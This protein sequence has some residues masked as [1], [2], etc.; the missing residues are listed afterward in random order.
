M[1]A[2]VLYYLGREKV[3]YFGPELGIYE[4]VPEPP[5]PLWGQILGY[6]E[7]SSFSLSL[8]I[9]L[10]CHFSFAEEPYSKK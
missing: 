8:V 5:F 3:V 6:S 7:P 2:T 1:N 10:G 9:F 4:W